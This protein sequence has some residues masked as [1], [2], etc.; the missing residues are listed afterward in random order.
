MARYVQTSQPYRGVDDGGAR[1][2]K[3]TSTPTKDDTYFPQQSYSAENSLKTRNLCISEDRKS[4]KYLVSIPVFIQLRIIRT[5]WS[6]IGV[7]QP[8]SKTKLGKN[9]PGRKQSCPE[10]VTFPRFHVSSISPQCIRQPWPSSLLRYP[11]GVLSYRQCLPFGP[12]SLRRRSPTTSSSSSSASCTWK[13]R[14]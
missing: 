12:K 3:Q 9:G 1:K 7:T 4:V 11:P 5:N 13:C 2:K 14:G 8:G 6:N 10:Y